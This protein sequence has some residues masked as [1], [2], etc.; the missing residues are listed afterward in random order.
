V[1]AKLVRER[2]GHQRQYVPATQ[3]EPR[4]RCTPFS[5]AR[6]RTPAGPDTRRGLPRSEV[7][8]V[9]RVPDLF[10]PERMQ[11][12]D[13]RGRR[14]H[15][16]VSGTGQSV[17]PTE[18]GEGERMLP[19]DQ[20]SELAVGDAALDLEPCRAAPDPLRPTRRGRRSGRR[21]QRPPTARR[22]SPA[23]AKASPPTTP[24]HG[25]IKDA[26]VSRLELNFQVGGEGVRVRRAGGPD[27][28]IE[29][30]DRMDSPLCR[31]DLEWGIVHAVRC[32]MR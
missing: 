15:Q 13:A 12:A 26:Y 27:N 21:S 24:R 2:G 31:L 17:F 11:E 18:F 10:V 8:L 19:A 25:S 28:R 6:S 5:P 14:E 3:P 20:P 9:H 30:Q 23:P 7:R 22:R 16:V 29:N 1:R 32:R 4:S